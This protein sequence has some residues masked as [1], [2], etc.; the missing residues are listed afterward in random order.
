MGRIT[1]TQTAHTT[2][3]DNNPIKH[4]ATRTNKQKCST[5]HRF[6]NSLL[7][8]RMV[9][10]ILPHSLTP[11]RP[12]T[13]KTPALPDFHFQHRGVHNFSFIYLLITSRSSKLCVAGWI[14]IAAVMQALARTRNTRSEITGPISVD[15]PADRKSV[16]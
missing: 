4:F 10:V 1:M 14:M 2:T 16:V 12:R 15:A 11:Q 7:W 13:R 5:A 9:L 8:P 3:P 6:N